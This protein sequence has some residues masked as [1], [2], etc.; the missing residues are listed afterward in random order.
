MKK[1]GFGIFLFV[2]IVFIIPP[3]MLL[4][5]SPG[6]VA[7]GDPVLGAVVFAAIDLLLWILSSQIL[8]LVVL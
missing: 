3:I 4:S 2:A 6:V 8:F 5:D 7:E 1:V